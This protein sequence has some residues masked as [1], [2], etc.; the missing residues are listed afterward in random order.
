MNSHSIRYRTFLLAAKKHG[1]FARTSWTKLLK[2]L[3]KPT[4]SWPLEDFAEIVGHDEETGLVEYFCSLGRFWAPASDREALA[5]T[6]IEILSGVYEYGDAVIH[7]GDIVCDM[8]CNRGTFTRLALDR[9]AARVIAFEPQPV[10]QQCL[11]KTF[12]HELEEG[13]LTL[14]TQPLWSEKKTLH[15][16]GIPMETVTLDEVIGAL[17]VPRVD[18]MKADIDGA[19]RHALMGARDTIA[20]YHP[21]IAFCV[22]RNPDDPEVIGNFLRTF[23]FYQPVFDTSGRYVYCWPPGRR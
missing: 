20:K 19:E 22:H 12:A 9:G 17:A 4:Q 7:P 15:F 2:L 8:G 13:R 21:R 10:Y 5:N 6:A 11:R 3:P 23:G 16:A 18:F 14:V 1:Y